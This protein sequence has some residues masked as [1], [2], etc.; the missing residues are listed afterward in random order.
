MKDLLMNEP[1]P[2]RIMTMFF[3]IDTSGSMEGD[4]IGAVDDAMDNI[5][6]IVGDI[7]EE[8]SDA[9]IRIAVLTFSSDW[10]WLNPQPVEAT[11]F[12]WVP[13]EPSGLTSLGAACRELNEKLSTKGFMASSSGYYAPVVILLSDGAPTDDFES[14]IAKLKRNKWFLNGIRAAIAIGDE[15]DKGVLEGFTGTGESVFAV[16]NIDQLKKIIR[17]VSVA[18]SQIGSQSSSAGLGS[19]QDQFTQ[20]VKMEMDMSDAFDD[21]FADGTDDGNQDFEGGW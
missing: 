12:R 3:L 14:G 7:S 17:M 2:R 13:T 1:T 21:K 11:Q 6:K 8:N 4:K 5:T 19:K 15:A 10:K 20:K 9:E 18:S 16:H